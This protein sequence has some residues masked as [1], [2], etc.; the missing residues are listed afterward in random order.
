MNPEEAVSLRMCPQ[1]ASG[2]EM[3]LI[4]QTLPTVPG[5]QDL[6]DICSIN[7]AWLRPLIPDDIQEVWIGFNYHQYVQD[8][9]LRA[10]T[11]AVMSAEDFK[12][13]AAR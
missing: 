12:E 13:L 8:R 3:D 7:L 1:Y 4:Q 11:Q 9:N 5:K 10:C 2:P 6:C